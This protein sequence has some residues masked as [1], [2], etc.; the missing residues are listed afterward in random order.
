M[1][2]LTGSIMTAQVPNAAVELERIQAAR[3]QV[4][5]QNIAIKLFDGWGSDKLIEEERAEVI[6]KENNALMKFGQMEFLLTDKYLL[7]LDHDSKTAFL[8][9]RPEEDPMAKFE[10]NFGGILETSESSQVKTVGKNRICELTFSEGQYG[11][12]EIMYDPTDYS[13]ERVSLYLN[14]AQIASEEDIPT[15]AR[16]EISYEQFVPGNGSDL[17]LSAYLKNIEKTP[18]LLPQWASYRLISTL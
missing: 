18:K 4:E 3:T 16:M 8:S 7:N 10:M 11:R 5:A 13:M 15:Q 14:E 9:E 2:L 17:K 12:I 6:R 1:L